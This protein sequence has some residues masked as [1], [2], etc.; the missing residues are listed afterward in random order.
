MELH[1]FSS[2]N[3][4]F[5]RQYEG[6]MKEADIA[7]VYYNPKVIKHKKLEPITKE[8]IYNAFNQKDL[9][10]FTNSKKL[11]RY[12][13]SHKSNHHNILMMSSGNFDEIDYSSLIRN[14]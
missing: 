12:L 3:E 14:K 4:K 6:S 13:K 9:L 11:E 1:T 5:L 7:I 8:Q 2:L 10:I